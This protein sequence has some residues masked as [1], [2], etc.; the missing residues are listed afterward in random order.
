[1]TSQFEFD[2]D[3]LEKLEKEDLTQCATLYELG[4]DQIIEIQ[5]VTSQLEIEEYSD[6]MG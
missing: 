3:Q 1:M 6:D 4:Y 2:R 5:R